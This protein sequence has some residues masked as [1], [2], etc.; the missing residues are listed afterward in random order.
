MKLVTFLATVSAVVALAGLPARADPVPDR[1]TGI[2]SVTACG[3]GGLTVLLES[4]ATMMFEGQGERSRVAMARAE[5]LAGSIVL[6]IEGE[7]D[8]LVLPPLDNLARCDTAPVS[9]SLLFAEAITFF[10]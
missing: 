10:S 1:V 6:T 4:N 3:G 5:W 2:W 8:E 9:F 7:T